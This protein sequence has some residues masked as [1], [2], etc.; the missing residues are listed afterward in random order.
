MKKIILFML[1]GAFMSTFAYAQVSEKKLSRAEKKAARKAKEEAQIQ[2]ML[3]LLQSK[4]WVLEAN[5]LY[6][7]QNQAFQI[8]PTLNFVGVNGDNGAI[9]LSLGNVMG[10]N[11]VGGVTLDGQIL[12]YQVQAGKNNQAPQVTMR[13]RGNAGVGSARIVITVNASG[14]ATAKYTGD[15]GQRIT[16]AGQLVSLANSSVYKGQSLF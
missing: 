16:F 2:E 10:W 4:H 1:L 5:T 12:D 6:N 9:Q 14:Q 7:R 11:G 15:Q 3:A 13:F 8:N